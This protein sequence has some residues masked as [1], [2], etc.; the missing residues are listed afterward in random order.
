MF[1]SFRPCKEVVVTAPTLVRYH[2]S[3]DYDTHLGFGNY[4]LR[5]RQGNS[6]IT[7]KQGSD[8]IQV[9]TSGNGENV[10]KGKQCHLVKEYFRVK[11]FMMLRCWDLCIQKGQVVP[12]DLYFNLEGTCIHIHIQVTCVRAA[13]MVWFAISMEKIF[14][15]ASFV[16]L[17]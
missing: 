12:Q 16:A 6:G 13:H 10:G 15:C 8:S 5:N 9:S 2:R 3:R 14:L 17:L 7:D 4:W 11:G 1:C